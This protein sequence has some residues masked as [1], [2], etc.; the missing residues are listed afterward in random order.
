MFWR[1]TRVKEPLGAVGQPDFSSEF[2]SLS[3]LQGA[4]NVLLLISPWHQ[5]VSLKN[6]L[7][8]PPGPDHGP[9]LWNLLE[10]GG[11]NLHWWYRG[12]HGQNGGWLESWGVAADLLQMMTPIIHNF[13]WQSHELCPYHLVLTPK[14]SIHARSHWTP[15]NTTWN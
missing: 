4:V 11:C 5:F 8:K 14:I 10:L 9:I 15:K 13:C 6:Q 12:L 3:L 2:W 1:S 7:E